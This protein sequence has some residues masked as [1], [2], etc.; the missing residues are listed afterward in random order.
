MI[1]RFEGNDPTIAADAYI[2]PGAQII[3]RVT[4]E[5]GSSVWFSA[6]LRG[7]DEPITVGRNSN[8]QDNATLHIDP[9][10]PVVVGENVV[11]GHNAIVHG[12]TIEDDVLIGM[13]ATV[14]TGA[15]IGTGS[16]VGA[17]ALVPEGADIPAGSLVV[18]IPA[19]AIRNTT[20][21]QVDEIRQSAGRY[22]L[23]AERFRQSGIAGQ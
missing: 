3:G 9:G 14:L 19:K 12:A 5:A 21:D 23:R 10:Y 11:I 6:V 20:P 18:G 4:L 7:D 1:L 8:V 22:R 17:G 2:A 16:I 13:H 15:R